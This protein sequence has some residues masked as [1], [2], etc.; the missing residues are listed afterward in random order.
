[1]FLKHFE[2]GFAKKNSKTISFD[3]NIVQKIARYVSQEINSGCC[4]NGLHHLLEGDSM[5]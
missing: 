3:A 1:M 5:W 2:L 4:N